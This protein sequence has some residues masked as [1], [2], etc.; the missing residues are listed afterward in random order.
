MSIATEIQRLQ[1]AKADIKAAIEEK[2][3]EV[4]NELIDGYA[5]KVDAV[6]D[7]GVSDGKKSEYDEFWD[8]FQNYGN[9]PVDGYEYAFMYRRWND[10]NFKPKYNIDGKKFYMAFYSTGI[11]DIPACL[12]RQGVILDTSQSDSLD[13]IF[14]ATKSEVL[15]SIDARSC[16][17][18]E[19][20]LYG[21]SW[22]CHT[23]G[24]LILKDDGSQKFNNNCFYDL[25]RLVNFTVEGVIGNNINFAWS[26]KLSKASIIS[27]VTHLSDT[28]GATVTFKKEAVNR[29]FGINVDDASTFP[30]GSEYYNLRYSKANWSFNYV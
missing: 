3:V 19:F 14:S 21:S 23:I 7:K 5:D 13:R 30:E 28:Q 1:E 11:K 10:E 15:P 16:V 4:G 17:S 18:K 20:T 22:H 8:I 29:E 25:P 12:E 26:P 9:G 2:G 27:I 6:Y 24:T